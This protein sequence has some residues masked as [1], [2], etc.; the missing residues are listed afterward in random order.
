MP[1][2][3]HRKERLFC[4]RHLLCVITYSIDN[5]NFNTYGV[6]ELVD[7]RNTHQQLSKND[8]GN[9]VGNGILSETKTTH[10]RESFYRMITLF[11]LYLQN[12]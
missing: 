7:R 3:K 9:L 1:N 5:H 2:E 4:L 12:G 6:N 10:L 11:M 8:N